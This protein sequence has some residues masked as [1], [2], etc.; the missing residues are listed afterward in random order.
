MQAIILAG[1]LGTRLKEVLQDIPK[2]MA[3]IGQK[4][5]LEYIL[6]FLQQQGIK[7]VILSVS[8]RYEM[9]CK[10]FG[11]DFLGMK[12]SYS[13]EE[14]ALGTGGAIKKALHLANSTPVFILNGDTYFDIS[15]SDLKLKDQS[16]ICLGLKKMQNFDR[17]GCVTIDEEGFIQSF[18]E[19]KFTQQGLINAGVYLINKSIF[20]G[21][22]EEVFSF[23]TFLQNHFKSLKAHAKV[24]EGFFIDIG[25]P[26]DYE[27]AKTKMQTFKGIPLNSH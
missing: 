1:G 25:I 15:L 24:F 4:P 19:K 18:E 14:K 8:Y 21:F 10:H 7:S 2:P 9:I 22:Y 23:E 16:K 27:K 6:Y 26:Q 13:I 5:F 11:G 17:Y 3:P 20:E 12:I